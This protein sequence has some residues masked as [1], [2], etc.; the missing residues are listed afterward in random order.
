M[1]KFSSEFDYLLV[2]GRRKGSFSCVY[3]KPRPP[4]AWTQMHKTIHVYEIQ[5]SA[6]PGKHQRLARRILIIAQIFWKIRFY[7]NPVSLWSNFANWNQHCRILWSFVSHLCYSRNQ[8]Y[9]QSSLFASL[10]ICVRVSFDTKR[11]HTRS[12]QARCSSSTTFNPCHR[13]SNVWHW[14]A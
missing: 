9:W 11:S 10:K 12:K 5:H 1:V 13:L 2:A 6:S 7:N 8:R 14:V 3:L 4:T